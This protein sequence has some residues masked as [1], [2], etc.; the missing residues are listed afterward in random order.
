LRAL[1]V[2]HRNSVLY[3][4]L[5]WACRALDSP[6]RRLPAPGRRLPVHLRVGVAGGG[7]RR[8][9]TRLQYVRRT[10][11]ES[12]NVPEQRAPT[13]RGAA[14]SRYYILVRPHTEPTRLAALGSVSTHGYN[15]Y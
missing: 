6:K 8:L 1:S 13:A 5:A 3:G 15:R 9:L 2:S 4:A 14:F 11:V 7:V 10:I 12:G